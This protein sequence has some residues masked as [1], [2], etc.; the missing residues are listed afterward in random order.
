MRSSTRFLALALLCGAAWS[1]AGGSSPARAQTPPT[2]APAQPPREVPPPEAAEGDAIAPFGANLFTGTYAAQREDGIN[3]DYTILPGDRVMVNAWG[4]VSVNDVFAV[5]T[6][7]NIFIPGIGPVRLAGVRNA[8]LTE[9]V[10]RG[11]ARV[12]RGEFGVYTNLLTASPVAVFVTGGV[13][14]PGRYAGIPSDSLLFFIDQAGGIDPDAGSFR[15]IQLIRQGAQVAELDLY[16]FLLR[17]Q[18]PTPQFTDGDIILVGRRGAVVE[19]QRPG[20]APVLVELEGERVLGAELLEIVSRGARMNAVTIRGVHDGQPTVQTLDA[21]TFERATVRDGD[22]LVFREDQQ[23]DTIVVHLEGEFLGPAELAVRR[24]ARL[25]DVLNFV[26]VDEALSRTD[27]IYVRRPQIAREQ[28]RALQESLDRLE[29][30]TFL[31]LSDT[32]GE[33]EIRVREAE[34]VRQFVDRA[35]N[36]VPLGR[37]VTASGGR[38]LNVLLS[39]G[40]VIVI[41]P[42]T[43]VVRVVGEVQIPHAVQYRP[44]LSILDYV[45]MSG[46]FTS[47]AHI[48][49]FLVMRPNAEIEVG[50]THTVVQPGDEVIVPPAI[51]DKWLQNGIDLAQVIYQIAVAAS[52]V[53]RPL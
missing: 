16:D 10:R 8:D 50:G 27:A 4:V 22:V 7:G 42:R 5:D 36:V 45:Q 33:S 44:D 35:R 2:A 28:R 52:V 31:A 37:M 1:S 43:T 14:R 29:R 25:L 48:G 47:R 34:L 38:Q 51:D 49:R 3:P 20:T 6:Q 30:S 24:G 40:D 46:G 23:P 17:G 32:A 21:G 18:L 15:H 13:R 26:P 39:D 41:P 12:Y 19:V 53:L 9:H 11:I